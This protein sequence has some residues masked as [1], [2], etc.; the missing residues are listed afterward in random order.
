MSS[1]AGRFEI[2]VSVNMKS[3]WCSFPVKVFACCQDK[4]DVRFE[5]LSRAFSFI[6]QV[7]ETRLS[8]DVQ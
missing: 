5:N 8:T 2:Q 3:R 4:Q 6:L 1:E 7:I